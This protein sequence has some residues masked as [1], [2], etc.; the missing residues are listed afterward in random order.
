MVLR[1]VP[2]HFL[3][4]RLCWA[5]GTDCYIRLREN[6]IKH[7]Q[8]EGFS[9]LLVLDN[10]DA[11]QRGEYGVCGSVDVREMREQLRIGEKC[12]CCCCCDT[13]Y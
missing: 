8:T 4:T 12:C 10:N 3:P 6:Q 1:D 9:G 2:K 7:C 11:R 5:L 13:W